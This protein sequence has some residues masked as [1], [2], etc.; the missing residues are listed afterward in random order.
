MVAF[1]DDHQQ[2]RL[3]TR[4]LGVQ[5]QAAL[6]AEPGRGLG[7]RDA[8]RVQEHHL[9]VALGQDGAGV[10]AGGVGLGGLRADM[11]AHHLVYQ[12]ALPAVGCSQQGYSQHFATVRALTFTFCFHQLVLKR[13]HLW[14]LVWKFF[15]Y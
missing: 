4:L 14:I 5:H 3:A 1:L 8:R 15:K 6:H 7:V 2:V 11:V 12:S 13:I 9:S 10:G